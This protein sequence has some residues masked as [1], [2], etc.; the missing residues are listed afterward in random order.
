VVS[1]RQ[2]VLPLEA[3]SALDRQGVGEEAR[4]GERGDLRVVVGERPVEVRQLAGWWV[5]S[6]VITA[7]SPSDSIITLTWF[8]TEREF[9]RDELRN[10]LKLHNSANLKPATRTPHPH[11]TAPFPVTS[12]YKSPRG[13]R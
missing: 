13:N 12:R 7:R 9:A 10:N 2:S 5:M 11:Q 3:Q 8:L 1:A 4:A 6:P